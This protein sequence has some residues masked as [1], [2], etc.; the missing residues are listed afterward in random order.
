MIV[1]DASAALELAAKTPVATTIDARLIQVNNLACAP[2]LIDLEFAQGLRR[3]VLLKRIGEARA[4]EAMADWS[5]LSI[6]RYPHEQFMDRIWHLRHNLTAY[7]AA[8]VA[9][10]EFL[11]APLLT[12]DAR[13]AR[14]SGHAAQIEVI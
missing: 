12:R 1:I 7:D 3:W 11:G 13:L 14:S 4:N 9:L 10:A 5:R 8:Y 2:H 6:L